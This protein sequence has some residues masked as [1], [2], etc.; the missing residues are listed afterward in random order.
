MAGLTAAINFHSTSLGRMVIDSAYQ[1][2]TCISDQISLDLTLG[3]QLTLQFTP[4]HQV[5]ISWPCCHWAPIT[6]FHSPSLHFID[7]HPVSSY[8]IPIFK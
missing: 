7:I 6:Q 8:F 3:N 2:L 5:G 4:V 1:R